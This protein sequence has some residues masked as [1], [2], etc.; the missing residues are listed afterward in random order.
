MGQ[1]DGIRH[2]F[3]K[4]AGVSHANQD[5]T[6]RQKI[7]KKC[8]TLEKLTLDHEEDNPHDRNAVRVCRENGEQIGY[9]QQELAEEVVSRSERGYRYA[10]FVKDVTGG[11]PSSPTHGINLLIIVALPGISDSEVQRYIDANLNVSR[12]KSGCLGLIVIAVI[13][14][15]GLWSAIA[16]S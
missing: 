4:V 15:V 13:L 14:S 11:R 6:S 5:G 1:T 8:R 7:I 16:A 9:L 3:T 10:A 2:F 12:S